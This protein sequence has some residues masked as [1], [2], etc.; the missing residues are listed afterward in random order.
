[1]RQPIHQR[2][3]LRSILLLSLCV[4]L[5]QAL[6]SSALADT[7]ANKKTLDIGI[8]YSIPPWVIPET[9]SG[10][11]LDIL[12]RTFDN[13]P[14]EVKPQYLPFA[15]IYKMFD[16][17]QLDGLINAKQDLVKKGFL[18]DPVI[19]F[20]N[21][22]ISLKSK[23]FPN[24]IDIEFMQDKS[25][26]AFQKAKELLGERFARM[27][28][29]NQRY[30]EVSK[31]QLQLN[32]L[33][34]RGIDFIVMDR[35]I[36]SYYWRQTVNNNQNQLLRSKFSQAVQFHNL[37]KASSYSYLFADQDVRD[38]FNKGLAQLK[39]SGQYQRILDRYSNFTQFYQ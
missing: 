37:F 38:T 13:T 10:I 29:H 39:A 11:E 7:G 36:F 19:A 17:D 28:T 30:Q 32:L 4:T 24:D 20:Q 6:F 26:L 14:Y 8:S 12:F 9:H 33:F 34:V 5:A 25:V 21:V 1:M 16:H 3:L 2:T 23:Q 22:A 18:S 35:S 15:L 31:Q 27:A